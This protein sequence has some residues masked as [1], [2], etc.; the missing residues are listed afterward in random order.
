MEVR[1]CCKLLADLH[2]PA[3]LPSQLIQSGVNDFREQ[4]L[5]GFWK[6][7]PGTSKQHLRRAVEPRLMA[8]L[9]EVVGEVSETIG[10]IVSS[11]RRLC[12]AL[13]PRKIDSGAIRV[14]SKATAFRD[15]A[16]PGRS[17]LINNTTGPAMPWG[18]P[19]CPNSKGG[20]C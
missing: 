18:A 12:F 14:C 3:S 4:L 11:R 19:Q 9:W 5:I 1:R 15:Y 17:S 6:L 7:W 10:G 8:N 13:V 16:R 2:G 20:G